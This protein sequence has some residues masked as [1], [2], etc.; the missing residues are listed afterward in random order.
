MFGT[1]VNAASILIGGSFGLLL[2][3]GLKERYKNIL[4]QALSLCIMFIGISGAVQ[5]L[6]QKDANPILF[7]ISLVL[8]SLLGESINIEQK[9]QTLGERLQLAVGSKGGNLSQGFVT[10]SLMFCVGTMAVLGSLDSGLTGNLNTLFAKS[11]LDGVTAILLASS[12]GVGVLLSSVSVLLYQGAIT[13]AAGLLQPY[14]GPEVLREISILGGIMI[15]ALGLNM[16]ELKKIQIG[17]MIPALIIPI[18]YYL[19]PVQALFHLGR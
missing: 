8:G 11:V 3:K 13:A 6:S 7:I 5:G 15:F 12:L 18:L 10:A 2:R 16:M 14:L 19:D 4:L 9:I 17:N 1:L